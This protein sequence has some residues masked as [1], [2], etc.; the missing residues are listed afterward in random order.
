MGRK[1]VLI[2]ENGK[3]QNTMEVL[4]WQGEELERMG[5]MLEAKSKKLVKQGEE[6]I[7][8]IEGI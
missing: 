1:P 8:I 2:T 6:L 3:V 5:K 4:H 7:K